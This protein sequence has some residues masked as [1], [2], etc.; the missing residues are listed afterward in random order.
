MTSII[1]PTSVACVL[2]MV[3]LAAAPAA[4]VDRR[5][6]DFWTYTMSFDLPDFGSSGIT[7]NG[8][9]TYTCVDQ[10]TVTVGGI[11]YD[12]NVM[13]IS[14]GTSGSVDF[15]GFEASLTLGGYVYETVDGM[16]TAKSDMITWTN[17]SFGLGTF[18]ISSRTETETSTEYSPP[19]LLRFDPS[20]VELGD[21]WTEIVQSTSTTTSWV[22]GTVSGT[23]SSDS[24]TLTYSNVVSSAR[25]TLTTEAGTFETIKITST[26]NDG[27]SEVY[28]WSPVVQNFV[29]E[30]TYAQG[31]TSPVMTMAL[32]DYSTGSSVNMILVVALGGA[33]LAVAIAVLIV[34]LIMRRR[35]INPSAYPP[36]MPDTPPSNQPQPPPG[37]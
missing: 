5:N 29:R 13:R 28:W 15:L 35:P 32:K 31:S 33:V 36:G 6:G 20:K 19:L 25:E 4:A 37:Q 27:D 26:D 30:D 1:A 12:V 24:S 18:Q 2:L 16:A 21:T 9:L 23:P 22:N 3:S 10:D 34:V 14:G 17:M 11:S 8:T 7:T